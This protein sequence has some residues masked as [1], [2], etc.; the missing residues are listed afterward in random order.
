VVPFRGTEEV[1]GISDLL[2]LLRDGGTPG[3]LALRLDESRGATLTWPIHPAAIS[4]RLTARTVEGTVLRTQLLPATQPGATD[5]TNNL[6]TCYR[7]E[8]LSGPS[9]VLTSDTVCGVP[10]IAT[11]APAAGVGLTGAPL[12]QLAGAR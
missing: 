12:Q 7:L 3:L 11:F 5:D 1:L 9:V 10:G 8:E 4:Y 2:C 6:T